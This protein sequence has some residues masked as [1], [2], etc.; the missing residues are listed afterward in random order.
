LLPASLVDVSLRRHYG[1]VLMENRKERW[2]E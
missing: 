1:V 2:K